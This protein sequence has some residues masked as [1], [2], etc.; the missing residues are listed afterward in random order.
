[1]LCR[2]CQ[3]DKAYYCQFT[4]TGTTKSVH[5]TI[6]FSSIQ[7]ASNYLDRCK[8]AD[9]DSIVAFLIQRGSRY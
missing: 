9:F 3:D 4:L 2:I 7:E 1:M 5:L 6:Q 8:K